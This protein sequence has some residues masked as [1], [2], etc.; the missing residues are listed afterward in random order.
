MGSRLGAL[1]SGTPEQKLQLCNGVLE[2]L[3]SGVNL[4]GEWPSRPAKTK[5]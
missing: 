1:Q 3:V 4:P 5:D 2:M